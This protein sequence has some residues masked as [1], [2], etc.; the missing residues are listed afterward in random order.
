MAFRRVEGG[1]YHYYH[2]RQDHNGDGPCH[3][4]APPAR[5][6]D[7]RALRA[8]PTIRVTLEKSSGVTTGHD[9]TLTRM[10]RFLEF[11]MFRFLI[12]HKQTG[13]WSLLAYVSRNDD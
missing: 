7:A 5:K 4:C 3:A 6:V 2:A 11:Q 9:A 10:R 1:H 13:A 12:G 8:R